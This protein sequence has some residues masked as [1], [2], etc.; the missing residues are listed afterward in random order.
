MK[1]KLQVAI[2]FQRD[3]QTDIVELALPIRALIGVLNEDGTKFYDIT[4]QQVFNDIDNYSDTSNC[5][6]FYYPMPIEDFMVSNTPE[7]IL[8]NIND[9]FKKIKEKVYFYSLETG[10]VE[11]FHLKSM[12]INE[13]NSK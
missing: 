6:G 8:K 7:A 13:F 2:L 12:P 4:G 5:L 9:Y 10:A 11:D 3:I 1:Q